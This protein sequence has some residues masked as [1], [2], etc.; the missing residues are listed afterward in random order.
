ML[1]CT[2]QV[3]AGKLGTR[4]ACPPPTNSRDKFGIEDRSRARRPG[5]ESKTT[6]LAIQF[7]IYSTFGCD[8]PSSSPEDFVK[9]GVR[10]ISPVAASISG[11]RKSYALLCRQ[12]PLVAVPAQLDAEQTIIPNF[13]QRRDDRRKIDFALAEHEMLVDSGPH[14]FNMD[15]GEPVGGF[16][17]FGGNGKF[18]QAMEVADVDGQSEPARVQHGGH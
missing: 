18:L 12:R 16:A 15:V 9:Y 17:D 8:G 10:S 6:N 5:I 1:A 4:M 7:P 11:R 3:T 2:G 13:G 14:I